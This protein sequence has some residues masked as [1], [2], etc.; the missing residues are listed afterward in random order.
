MPFPTPYLSSSHQS[1]PNFKTTIKTLR[2]DC[3]RFIHVVFV[4]KVK[5]VMVLSTQVILC[6]VVWRK[7]LAASNRVIVAKVAHS[8]NDIALQTSLESKPLT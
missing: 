4:S 2:N 3:L 6:E 1:I 8:Q 7:I 5:A